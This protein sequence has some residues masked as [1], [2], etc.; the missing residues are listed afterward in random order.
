MAERPIILWLRRDLRL[1]DHPALDAAIAAGAPIVPVFVLDDDVAGAWRLGGASRWWLAGS[2]G[3]LGAELRDRG[4]R[5]VLR[6]GETKKVLLELA[7]E[8]GAAA[9]YFTRGYEPFMRPLESALHSALAAAGVG[10]RRFGGQMFLEPEAVRNKSGEPF[11]VFTPFYKQCQTREP[12]AHSLAA[13]GCLPAL[14]RWPPG[15]TLDSWQ[16]TPVKPD[17]AAQMREF[18]TPGEDGAATRLSEFIDDALADYG[19]HRDRPDLDGTSRLSPHLAFGEISP[20]QIW[21]A[22]T[23]AA[24]ADGGKQRGADAYIRELY[25]R[26]FS[27]HLLFHRPD[28]PEKPFRPEFAALPWRKAGTALTTWRSGHTGYPIVDAGLRQLWALGWMHN[29]VRMVAASFLTKH[30]LIRWQEGEAWFWDT[31]VD[32]DLANNAA[33]WQWVV[34]SGAD[35]A[36]YF[37]IFNPVLQGRK[38]DAQGDYVRRWVPELAKMP[39]THIHAPWDAPANV[40]RAAG[41]TLGETYPLPIIAHEEG[42]RQALAAYEAVKAANARSGA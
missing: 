22:I 25:W 9:V 34:G 21:H 6:R 35:A 28:L 16:L 1:G 18:W 4:S 42:R 23:Q 7:R 11:K 12:P 2:L 10:C 37:R 5:L 32:A 26:E 3:A 40:L 15:E 19:A 24:E 39:A 13:A 27:T 8:T 41:V 29:R 38:F 20:R 30:L 33:S 31:L 14:R 36:P 17:W